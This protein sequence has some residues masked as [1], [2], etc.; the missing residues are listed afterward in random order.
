MMADPL[1]L[2]VAGKRWQVAPDYRDLLLG[3]DGLRLGEWLRAGQ[4]SVVKQ[5]PHRAVYHV[6]LAGRSFYVKHYPLYG[7]RAWVRQLVRP[8]KARTEYERALAVAAASVPTF[9]PLALGEPAGRF[10]PG[11]SFLVTRELEDT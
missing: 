7:L 5:G 1:S 2:I 10:G 11:A 9:V 4:A 6:A 8:A 3:P